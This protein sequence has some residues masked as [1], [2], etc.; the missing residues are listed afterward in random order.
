M[1]KKK[2][3]PALE[4]ETDLNAKRELFCR[5]YAQG[6]GTFGNA[7]ASYAEAYEIEI[8]DTSLVDK[9]GKKSRRRPTFVNR[10]DPADEQM[11]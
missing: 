10:R 8:G 3:K 2:A 4:P 7:T 9:N 1:A 5:Y 6:G 11:R